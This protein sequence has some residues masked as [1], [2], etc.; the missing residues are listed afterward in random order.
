[1]K[2]VNSRKKVQGA[3]H[4]DTLFSMVSLSMTYAEQSRWTEAEELDLQVLE[5]LQ[6]KLGHGHPHTLKA[7][8]ILAL[9]WKRQG[10]VEDART[11]MAEIEQRGNM[12]DTR[13]GLLGD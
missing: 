10:R 13:T 8:E 6:R 1:M 7:K 4:S 2:I 11:L 5:T 9:N 12:P 3:E